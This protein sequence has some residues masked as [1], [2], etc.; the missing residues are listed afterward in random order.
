[1]DQIHGMAMCVF[2]SLPNIAQGSDYLENWHERK[3][4][5]F[6]QPW[7]PGSIQ[8]TQKNTPSCENCLSLSSCANTP[9]ILSIAVNARR[10]S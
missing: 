3:F 10:M 8:V 7:Y 6:F 4:L 5:S 9:D 1:M 2:R